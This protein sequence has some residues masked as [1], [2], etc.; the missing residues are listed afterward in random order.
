MAWDHALKMQTSNKI[1]IFMASCNI[2]DAI[3]IV[4]ME[5]TKASLGEGDCL[6]RLQNIAEAT[7]PVI[8]KKGVQKLVTLVRCEK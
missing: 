5:P 4:E 7:S 6:S 8:N 2:K 1:N 3:Y